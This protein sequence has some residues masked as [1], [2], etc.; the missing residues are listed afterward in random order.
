MKK[1]IRICNLIQ[2]YSND[3]MQKFTSFLEYIDSIIDY[4]I[5][6]ENLDDSETD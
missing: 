4:E 3:I 6:L 5:K 2:P 1:L